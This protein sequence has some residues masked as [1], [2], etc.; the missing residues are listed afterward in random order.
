MNTMATPGREIRPDEAVVSVEAVPSDRVQP[1][2]GVTQVIAP[3]ACDGELALTAFRL[4]G[5]PSMPL[6]PASVHRD[7]MDKLEDGW[8]YRC[9]PMTIANQSGWFVLNTHAIF[10]CWNGSAGRDGV[11]ITSFSKDG[12]PC[13][14]G[15]NFGGGILTWDIPFLFR[16]SPG[17]NLWVRGPA[18]EARRGAVPLE[19]IVETDWSV[20][21]FTMNWKL[22]EPNR[23]VTF[24]V[25]EPICMIFPV[26]RG[27]LERFR[28]TVADLDT[29]PD[30]ARSYHHFNGSRIEFKAQRIPGSRTWQRH[31]TQGTS[32]DGTVS[33]REHQ[34][35]LRLR[36]FMEDA[37][38]SITRNDSGPS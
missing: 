13:P 16:T 32:S 7:W 9:L 31:Y 10:A 18:N 29:V 28:A 36:P 22:T 12:S 33:A 8:P 26:L 2:E 34:T 3:E 23:V 35:N 17:Y 30:I 5:R 11:S 24:D 25:G 4:P 21:T 19:G 20:A 6:A 38:G 37:E 1:S 27:N 14:V 15:S